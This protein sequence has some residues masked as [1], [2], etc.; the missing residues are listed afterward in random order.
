METHKVYKENMLRLKDMGVIPRYLDGENIPMSRV[1][2]ERTMRVPYSKE[3]N[4]YDDFC[5]D[6][7]NAVKYLNND[8]I[9]PDELYTKMKS[10]A[11]Q[12]RAEGYKI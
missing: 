10:T 8:I 5:R 9:I 1:S 11:D 3:Y 12:L 7:A 6:S 2:M 4:T